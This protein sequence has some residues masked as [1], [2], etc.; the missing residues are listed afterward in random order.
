MEPF[1]V[2]VRPGAESSTCSNHEGEEFLYVLSGRVRI[3]YGG[4]TYRLEPGDS[5]YY[6]S[7]VPHELRAE[8]DRTARILAVVFAPF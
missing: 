2:D 7:V 4:T 1:V 6:D 5:I 8:S 3:T